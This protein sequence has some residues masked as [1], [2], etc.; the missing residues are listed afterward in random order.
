MGQGLYVLERWTWTSVWRVLKLVTTC[1]VTFKSLFL[2]TSFCFSSLMVF[3]LAA[4]TPN[5][6][7]ENVENVPFSKNFFFWLRRILNLE[8]YSICQN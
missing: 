5:T 8:E 3:T 7:F 6:L 4:S 1:E 2:L